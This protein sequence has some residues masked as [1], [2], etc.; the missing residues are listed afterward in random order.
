MVRHI[1]GIILALAV[2]AIVWVGCSRMSDDIVAKVGDW[3]ITTEQF[4]DEAMK[5]CERKRTLHGQARKTW[6]RYWMT[7]LY[8]N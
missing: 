1:T 2:V 8:E 6:K 5:N 7:W 3:T 4:K